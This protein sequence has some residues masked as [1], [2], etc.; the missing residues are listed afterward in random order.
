MGSV[1]RV[2]PSFFLITRTGRVRGEWGHPC[3]AQY[4]P[5]GLLPVPAKM[6][7]RS[8]DCGFCSSSCQ[9]KLLLCSEE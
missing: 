2:E 6:L 4:Q 1:P 7:S 9:L 3:S 8:G 5:R